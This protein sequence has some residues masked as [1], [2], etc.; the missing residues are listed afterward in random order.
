MDSLHQNDDLESVPPLSEASGCSAIEEPPRRS[1][2]S[3]RKKTVAAVF[4]I[5]V[6]ASIATGVA[7][8]VKPSRQ[9]GIEQSSVAIT[10]NETP[11]EQQVIDGEEF[12]TTELA[13]SGDGITITSEKVPVDSED[14][15]IAKFDG[16]LTDFIVTPE[17]SRISKATNGK[18][19]NATEGLWQ[20]KFVTDNYAWENK[21]E[22]RDE[23]GNL[24][25][26]G[27]PAGKNYARLT[28]YIGS[29][30]VEAGK[31]TIE[32]FDK[33]EDGICCGYG[34]G[35]MAI[36]VNGKT[37]AKT[38][39]SNFA[40]F[41]ES[42]DISPSN[43]VDTTPKPTKKPTPKPINSA[44]EPTTALHSVTV[45]VKTDE[46]G[47]E[48]GYKFES[49]NGVVLVNKAKG[50]LEKSTLYEDKFL[51]KDGTGLEKGQYRLTLDDDSQA[52]AP[53]F[54][55]VEVDGEE[56]MFD[57]KSK[58]YLIN[59][60]IEP[61]MTNRDKEWL[62]AHNTRRKTFHEAQGK[63]YNPL[64]WSTELAEAASNWVDELM[65]MCVTRLE[66]GHEDG[67]NVSTRT[68]NAERN[69]GPDVILPRWVD[70]KVGL[71]YPENQSRTQ[72]LWRGTRYVGCK[73]KMTTRSD[74]SICYASVCRY[75]RAGNCQ[76]NNGA[77][78][79]VTLADRSECGRACPGETC[80]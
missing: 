39:D 64:V 48:T 66:Q 77:W 21:W 62:E 29:M 42:I 59:V 19:A 68:A 32:L 6:V 17:I 80:Y 2:F 34:N 38:D 36:K 73:D 51:V 52:I 43:Q 71:G 63:K 58:S 10:D 44:V 1:F 69:E 3:G 46:N 15:E 45:S 70:K 50:S 79:E 37:V 67:E 9:T 5:V 60:G 74:G 49:V 72:V 76:I 33:S 27:P 11:Q 55:A 18:C 14:V 23:D 13:A 57:H 41:K 30:C 75:A 22:F 12:E 24:V 31:Y 78:E 40:S 25:M 35:T 47:E 26:S 7:L 4:S 28:T 56:V 53:G 54:Y 61:T 16:P 20:M 8:S 65:I